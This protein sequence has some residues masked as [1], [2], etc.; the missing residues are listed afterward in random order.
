MTMVTTSRR[1]RKKAE[2]RS[3]IV[4]VAVRLFAERG[5]E[6]VTV[7][8]IAE[9]ADV[10]KGTIYNYFQAKEDIVVAFMADFERSVQARLQ[11]FRSR[12]RSAADVLTDYVRLQFE[13][14]QPFH[15]FVRVFLAHMFLR[16]QHFLPYMAEMQEIIDPPLE[17]LFTSLRERGAI[18][19]D[20]SVSELVLVFKTMHL[21]MTALWAIEGP[22][23]TH[24]LQTVKR[25]IALFCAG[26]ETTV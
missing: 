9:A 6:A 26:I 7:D 16:T 21:G 25:E 20:V 18:R 19:R 24:T 23:F 2:I 3:R 13:M 1:V 15:T 22:P 4:S 10:G 8:E 14:K 11:D 12:R 5:I 17:A